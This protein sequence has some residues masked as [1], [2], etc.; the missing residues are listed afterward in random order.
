MFPF[1]W[2][3]VK[4]ARNPAIISTDSLNQTLAGALTLIEASDYFLRVSLALGG[5]HLN[6]NVPTLFKF[7]KPLNF[8]G[9]ENSLVTSSDYATSL[10]SP[11]F[12]VPYIVGR[13]T[14]DTFPVYVP[15]KGNTLYAYV[16]AATMKRG[17]HYV[18]LQSI[19]RPLKFRIA[20][21]MGMLYYWKRL[22][23]C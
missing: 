17:C 14:L 9:K 8:R 12:P 20:L 16:D 4:R 18:F 2:W 23:V 5:D 7:K 11:K 3:N 21:H 15:T 1:A 19:L 6:E 13:S 22:P 10:G